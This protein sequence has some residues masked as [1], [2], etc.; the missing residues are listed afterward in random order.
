SVYIKLGGG[1]A[2]TPA[3]LVMGG[4]SVPCAPSGGHLVCQA[5][6]QVWGAATS[7]GCPAAYSTG[8]GSQVSGV[9]V[10]LCLTK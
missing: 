2:G 6:Q 9:N 1:G 7:A 4:Y 8:G 10:Y 3:G 5:A